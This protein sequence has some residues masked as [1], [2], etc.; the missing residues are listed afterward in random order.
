MST[1]FNRPTLPELLARIQGDIEGAVT[2]VTARLRRRFERAAAFAI[3]S[4]SDGLHGH[5]A[6]VA[7]QIFPDTAVERYLLRWCSL[8]GI[9]RKAAVRA[10]GLLEIDGTGGDMPTGTLWVRPTDGR[11]YETLADVDDLAAPGTVQI[12]AL[13]GGLN[14]NVDPGTELQLVTPISG[15]NGTGTADADGITGGTDQETLAALLERLIRRIQD[16]PKG[17]APGDFIAWAT[18]VAGVRRAWEYVGVD[19]TGNPGLGL[20]ALAF[21]RDDDVDE[22]DDPD[23]IPDE[24]EVEAMQQYM[25]DRFFGEE[26]IVF[27]PTPVPLALTIQLDPNTSTIRDAV[28]AE[29]RDLLLRDAEPGGLML[30]SRINEAISAAAG[31]ADHILV[32]PT[33]NV[34]HGFGEMATYDPD[35]DGVIE[36]EDMP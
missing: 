10:S 5:I 3:A 12:R 6:W 32:S 33:A 9:T 17:G 31:E 28:R 35:P 13:I 14:S 26:V 22:F 7:D 4:V 18:E 29:I 25:D 8:F 30:I 23:I 1:E 11:Q 27:A 34:E 19:G 2:G 21:V 36:F 24:D 15:I 16:P 20:V